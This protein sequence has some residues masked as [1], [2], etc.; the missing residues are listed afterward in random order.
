MK[1][2]LPVILLIVT[3]YPCHTAT[4]DIVAKM[5]ENNSKYISR[6]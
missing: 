4:A 6:T 2:L 3:S 5:K 1:F